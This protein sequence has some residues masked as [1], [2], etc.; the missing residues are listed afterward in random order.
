MRDW[1][2][3]WRI[4]CRKCGLTRDAGQAGII[5]L[6]AIGRSY[7]LGFCE[8]CNRLRWLVCERYPENSCPHCRYTLDDV[9]SDTC[10]NCKRP[11]PRGNG[12]PSATPK[13]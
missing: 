10:P 13:R 3:G 5:R 8:R 4:R 12:A 1:A 2:P 7:K 11:V 6:F 9:A